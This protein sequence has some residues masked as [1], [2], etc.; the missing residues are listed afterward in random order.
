MR[1]RHSGTLYLFSSDAA[2]APTRLPPTL[3]AISSQVK[4]CCSP[5]SLQDDKPKLRF[6]HDISKS[7]T[8]TAGSKVVVA[9]SC[10]RNFQVDFL[11][12]VEL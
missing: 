6:E 3:S 7:G 12:P 1:L 4:R 5:S 10:A 9:A 8:A 11:Q 2:I